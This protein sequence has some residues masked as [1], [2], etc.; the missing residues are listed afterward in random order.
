[1]SFVLCITVVFRLSE[2]LPSSQYCELDG[3]QSR[4]EPSLI[5]PSWP[6][7]ADVPAP[8]PVTF[9]G[10]AR[11][12]R[13]NRPILRTICLT[14]PFG[15]KQAISRCNFN[16]HRNEIRIDRLSFRIICLTGIYTSRYPHQSIRDDS[17]GKA[18]P[19]PNLCRTHR[20]AVG[21]A[22]SPHPASRNGKD[23]IKTASPSALRWVLAT[24]GNLAT[25]ETRTTSPAASRSRGDY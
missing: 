9:T 5:G 3:S 21:A 25:H 4:Q 1:M 14:H 13:R 6:K 24:I 22:I 2:S 11:S 23:V 17:S 8:A 15:A 16:I 12:V 18:T 19:V 20:L 10:P 7:S